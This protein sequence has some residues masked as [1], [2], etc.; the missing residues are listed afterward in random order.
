MQ[1]GVR[2]APPAAPAA[3]PAAALV[4]C[5]VAAAVAALAA[6]GV[7]SAVGSAVAALDIA[8]VL[9]GASLSPLAG[10]G[11][12]LQGQREPHVPGAHSSNMQRGSIMHTHATRPQHL[13]STSTSWVHAHYR[14]THMCSN[15]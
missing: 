11:S 15:K 12:G 8:A 5:V 9:L 10:L 13:Y 6:A 1:H 14:L 7:A 2:F 3:A 4:A